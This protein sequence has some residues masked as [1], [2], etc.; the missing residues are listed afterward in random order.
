MKKRKL[1]YADGSQTRDMYDIPDGIVAHLTRKCGGNVHDRHVVDVTSRSFEKESRGANRRSGAYNNSPD[2]AADLEIDSWFQSAYRKK[3]EHIQHTRN[4]RVCYDF[5]ER[6][7]VPTH[8]TVRRHYGPPGNPHLKSWLVDTSADGESWR[9][10]AR[11]EDNQ[12]LNG[13]RFTGTFAVAGGRECRF[14]RLVNVGRNYFGDDTFRIS[15]WETFGSL[16]G[17]TAD[18]SDF[19]DVTSLPFL[20][21]ASFGSFHHIPFLAFHARRGQEG[22]HRRAE[23]PVTHARHRVPRGASPTEER[24][25]PMRTRRSPPAPRL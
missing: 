17:Q 19:S 8:Y 22:R 21:A 1:R 3:E 12:Q 15:A 16:I 2:C 13:S 6:R 4:N 25:E 7:I 11:E 10:V 18:S 5:K 20:S 23:V 14:I 24:W 9:E